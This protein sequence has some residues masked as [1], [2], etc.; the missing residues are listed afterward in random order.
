MLLN[1]L[2]RTTYRYGRPAYDS[3]NE[4]RLRP[5]EHAGQHRHSYRLTSRPTAPQHAYHDL[6][7]NYVEVVQLSAQHTEL[8]IEAR[9]QVETIALPQPTPE[10]AAGL[11]A[12]ELAFELHDYLGDSRYVPITTDLWRCA[13]DVLPHGLSDLWADAWALS[14]W[15]HDAFT[16]SPGATQAST[17][18]QE[19]LSARQ[20]VCQDYA[21][22][23]LGLCRSLKLPA[24]YVS[25]YFFNDSY[26][27]ALGESEASHAWVEV[28]L[29][30][31]GWRGIDP[32]HQRLADERYVSIA[33]GRD[34]D[35]IRPVSGAYR[36]ATERN[37]DVHVR[38]TQEISHE[39]A[40]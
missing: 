1:I 26:D 10:D 14:A 23:L 8:A 38:I 5:I 30:T 17:T 33:V 7:R 9:S 12:P 28:Y 15:V 31:Q 3:F 27:E 32:T 37:M 18:A 29:P 20:G 16:Y 40:T 34:Y 19:A 36:G 22:V 2:H 4:V 25:G 39:T 21:H 24:R 35:D 11:Q 13:V 6:Y